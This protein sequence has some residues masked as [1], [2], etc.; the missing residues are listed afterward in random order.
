MPLAPLA[1]LRPEEIREELRR[2]GRFVIYYYC[3]T[4]FFWSYKKPSRIL[5]LRPGCNDTWHG[6]PVSVLGHHPFWR[7][8]P[9]SLLSLLLGGPLVAIVGLCLTGGL[10]VW[11]L[12]GDQELNVLIVLPAFILTFWGLP[13]GYIYLFSCLV[14]NCR[15]GQ[16]VTTEV[17]TLLGLVEGPAEQRA[18]SESFAANGSSEANPQ[19]MD[20]AA[21]WIDKGK[22]PT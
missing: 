12:P 18:G 21:G 9:Y 8:V 19:T 7:G 13:W 14:T 15:G 1:P 3:V 2:G 20:A 17:S 16:D 5:L 6:M 4:L 22:L 11:N 10:L